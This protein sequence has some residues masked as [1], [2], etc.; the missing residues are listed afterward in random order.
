MISTTEQSFINEAFNQAL[1]SPCQMRHGCV[2][3]TNGRIVGRGFNHYRTSSKDG[4]VHNSCTCHAE[5]S[6]IRDCCRHYPT[7]KK[8]HYLLQL[9]VAKV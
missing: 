3:V 9:K 4:F 7:N 5:I 1:L 2:V 8:K 6:A